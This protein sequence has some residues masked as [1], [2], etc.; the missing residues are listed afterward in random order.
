[1]NEINICLVKLLGVG[2]AKTKV[3]KNFLLFNGTPNELHNSYRFDKRRCK[4]YSFWN[5]YLSNCV[6][7]YL[8]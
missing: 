5:K 4:D 6:K 1:M 8:I 3:I 7:L 2:Q